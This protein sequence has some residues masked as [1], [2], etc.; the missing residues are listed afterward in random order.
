[1]VTSHPKADKTPFKDGRVLTC[2]V[3][4]GKEGSSAYVFCLRTCCQNAYPYYQD[5]LPEASQD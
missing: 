1:M 4:Q 5:K 2:Q 3:G